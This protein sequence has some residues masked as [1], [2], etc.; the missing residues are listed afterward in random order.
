M[1]YYEPSSSAAARLK[2]KLDKSK[3]TTKLSEVDGVSDRG[4]HTGNP[5]VYVCLTVKKKPFGNYAFG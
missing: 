4:G 1:T 3:I 2:A 5:Y